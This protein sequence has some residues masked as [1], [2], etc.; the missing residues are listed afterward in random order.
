MTMKEIEE[1]LG[2]TSSPAPLSPNEQHD[3]I[4]QIDTSAIDR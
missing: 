4:V 3:T 1:A 2:E